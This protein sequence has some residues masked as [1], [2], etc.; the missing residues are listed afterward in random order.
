MKNNSAIIT[1]AGDLC[2]EDLDQESYIIQPEIADLFARSDLN[3]VNLE[4]PLTHSE[5]KMPGRV[6]NFKGRPVPGKVFNHFDVFSLANNHI[7]DYSSAGLL[8]TMDF[9]VSRQKSFFGAGQDIDRATRPLT[10]QI[11][12]V[13]LAFIGC[14]RWDNAGKKKP[15]TAPMQIGWI[16][17]TIS[18]LKEQGCFVVI[19][20]HWNYEYV[21][22]PSPA[23]RRFGHRLIRAGADLIVGS[24]PH[25]IQGWEKYRDKYIFHS[26][27][28]FIFNQFDLSRPEFA[29]TFLLSITINADHSSSFTIH[30]VYG[31]QQGL[32]L[33]SGDALKE[34]EH[35]LKELT[36]NLKTPSLYKKLF[37]K[38]AGMLADYSMDNLVKISGNKSLILTVIKRLHKIRTQDILIKLHSLMQNTSRH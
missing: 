25:Q 9:I 8:D 7:L 19:F 22:Y 20:P 26:L 2:L 1:F 37:Y 17:R 30:P 33:L 11:G 6:F 29:R 18:A 4:S 38:E 3:V 12:D 10:L 13:R 24:H 15:G 32:F 23:E 35:K 31:T 5:E 16:S 14:T 21:D 27:G 34:F 36:D 28:N